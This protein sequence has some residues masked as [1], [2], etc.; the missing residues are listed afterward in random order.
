MSKVLAFEFVNF[1]TLADERVEFDESGILNMVGYNDSGKSAVL[2]GI[3]VLMRDAH[4]T[5][6][7]KFIQDDKDFFAV[8]GE[9]EGGIEINKYKYRNG[10]SVWEFKK[11]GEMV[12]TNR[13]SEGVASTDGM[14]DI[15]RKFMNVVEDE[16][17]GE[18]LNF[19]KNVDKLFLIHT[20]G[21]DNYKIINSVLRSEVLSETVSRINKTKNALQSKV[22][23]DTSTSRVLKN[24]RDAIFILADEVLSEIKERKEKLALN[25][26]RIE[27]LSSTIQSKQFYDEVVVPEELSPVDTSRLESI[28]SIIQLNKE[29]DIPVFDSLSEIDIERLTLLSN[30]KELAQ[31]KDI[32]IPPELPNVATNRL[33]DIKA[34]GVHY[35]AV[36]QLSVNLAGIEKEYDTLHKEL[37]RLSKEHGIKVCTNCGTVVA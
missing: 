37:H 1:M 24:E 12:Y 28:S 5:L 11:N 20:S 14:P 2:T 13:L 29:A 15:I 4:P 26:V 32:P 30:I 23:S 17:T 21:G 3:E 22:L 16:V 27:Y 8:G 25:K 36:Y 35:N 18:Q 19:R 33:E 9:F 7:S 31:G 10:K 6:Q 34:I